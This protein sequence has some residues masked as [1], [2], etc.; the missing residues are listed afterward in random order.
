MNYAE[1]EELIHQF[2]KDLNGEKYYAI[3]IESKWCRCA[4]KNQRLV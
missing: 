3:K 1:H 2:L 4:I